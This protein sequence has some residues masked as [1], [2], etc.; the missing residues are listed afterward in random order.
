[1]S[2]EARK[3]TF[4]T[5]RSRF[6]RAAARVARGDVARAARL[7]DE[8]RADDP[9]LTTEYVIAQELYRDA[10]IMDRL[11]SRLRQA[12]LPNAEPTLAQV[13]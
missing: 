8:A 12:G 10:R 13:S 9:T 2:L 3:L 1:M 6:Y 7:I 11:L 5:R 4:Q